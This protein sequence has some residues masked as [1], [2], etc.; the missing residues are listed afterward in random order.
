MLISA[1]ARSVMS[2]L[3]ADGTSAGGSSNDIENPKFQLVGPLI[4]KLSSTVQGRIL[5]TA[6]E[7]MEKG[8]WWKKSEDL[9]YGD[10][11]L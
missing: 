8:K 6:G 1:I 10:V 3:L 7:I 9:R 5:K 2:A 11:S 4:G